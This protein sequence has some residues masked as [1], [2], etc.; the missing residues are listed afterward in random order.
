MYGL[1]EMYGA[2][3][4]VGQW[5]APYHAHFRQTLP[6]LFFDKVVGGLSEDNQGTLGPGK[7]FGQA[8]ESGWMAALVAE[9]MEYALFGQFC[10]I[11]T[12]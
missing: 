1:V 7:P 3:G 12:K 9:D 11:E 6:S 5:L 4:G 8:V 2:G 10:C